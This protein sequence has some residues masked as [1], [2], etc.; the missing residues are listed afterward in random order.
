MTDATA[1]PEGFFD[2]P[3]TGRQLSDFSEC[4]RR[5]LLSQFVSEKEERRYRGAAAVLHQGLRDAIVAFYQAG[6]DVADAARELRTLFK[7]HFEG[8]LCADAIEESRT[9]AR[10][11]KSLDEFARTWVPE[12]P[13]ARDTDLRLALTIDGQAFASSADLLF[14]DGAGT[15]VMR[16]NSRRPAPAADDLLAEPS[17]VLLALAADQLEGDRPKCVGYYSLSECKLVPIEIAPDQIDYVRRDL[18]S[19]AARMRRETQFAPRKGRQCRWCGA[20]GRCEVWR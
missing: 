5:F 6:E 9:E 14:A 15:T 8:A 16:L 18:V 1:L 4:P 3:L 7:K 13:T 12:H 2:R 11:L 20:R 19:R 17:A 10:G